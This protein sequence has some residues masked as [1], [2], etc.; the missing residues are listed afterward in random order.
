MT[1]NPSPWLHHVW[2]RMARAVQQS[3]LGTS[4]VANVDD[5]RDW[6]A[7]MRETPPALQV[8]T[9]VRLMATGMAIVAMLLCVERLF[10]LLSVPGALLNNVAAL[11]PSR[12]CLIGPFALAIAGTVPHLWTLLFAPRL[13][14]E[15]HFRTVASISCVLSAVAWF[16]LAVL[17][18]G[19]DVGGLEWAYEVRMSMMLF[20][21]GVNAVSVNSQ[22]IREE[23]NAA[24]D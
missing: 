22:Q 18:Q 5:L 6:A 10:Y 15:K 4:M 16:Y 3:F 19:L 24:H 11:A 2:Q 12:W 17:A 9:E 20:V 7:R 8:Q 21:A 23:L 13:L 1:L 14:G